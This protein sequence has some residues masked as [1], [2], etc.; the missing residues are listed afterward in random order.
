MKIGITLSGGL[1]KGAFQYGFLK[2]FLE[3]IPKEDIEIV[4]AS[5]IGIINAYALCA[6]KMEEVEKIWR[7]VDYD[8]VFDVIKD[9]WKNHYIRKTL[10]E[11]VLPEDKLD[12]PFYAT[13]TYCPLLLIGRYYLLEGSHYK[14]WKK[15]FR[16]SIAFPFLTGWPK[17]YKFLPT[18]DGGACDNIPIYPLLE[19]H[20]LDLILCIHFDSKYVVKKKWKNKKTIILDLD[21]S[22]GNDLR[23]CSFNFSNRVLSRMLDSG[24]EYGKKV[25]ERIFENGYGNLEGIKE[26]VDAL[27]NEEFGERMRSGTIDRSVTLLNG[28][29]QVFRGKH[30]IKPLVK[31]KKEKR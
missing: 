9:C 6:N 10:N 26:S 22:L 14:K 25:C 19:K 20:D 15:F 8:G 29:A 17:F 28:F 13:I 23:K 2:A 24:Y 31:R 27:Y 18:M 16:A 7:S 3:Y 30:T 1:A 11:L 5:S 21:A 12:I 4:S